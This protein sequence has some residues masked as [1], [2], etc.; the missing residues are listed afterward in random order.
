MQASRVLLFGSLLTFI[1]GLGCGQALSATPSFTIS[2]SNAIMPT[3]GAGS[4][5]FTLTSVN[6][7]SG[8]VMVHCGDTNAPQGAKLPICG[9]SVAPAIYTLTVNEVL[10][11]S[12]ALLASPVPCSDPCPAE[13]LRRPRQG[14]AQSL[15]LAGALLL[16]LGFQRR[17]RRRFTLT[18]LALGTLAGFAAISACGGSGRTLTPGAW[19]YTIDAVDVTTYETVSTTVEVTVPSG[20]STSL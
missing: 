1:F 15:A 17:A 13:L 12:I 4:I 18:V 7:Y 16:Y 5:P 8:T 3:S 9:G 14:G 2:A 20:V 11:G 10:N 6:G 19:Q